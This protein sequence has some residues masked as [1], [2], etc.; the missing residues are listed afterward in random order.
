M[1][2]VEAKAPVLS[3]TFG[4]NYLRWVMRVRHGELS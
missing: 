4:S 2:R 1:N 3:P